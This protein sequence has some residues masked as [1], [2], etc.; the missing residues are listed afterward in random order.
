MG[1]ERA[2]LTA[3]SRVLPGKALVPALVVTGESG[4]QLLCVRGRGIFHFNQEVL[5]G[6]AAKS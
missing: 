5:R 6:P 3:V 2:S 4:H 1:E